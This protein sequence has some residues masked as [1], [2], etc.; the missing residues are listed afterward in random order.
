MKDITKNKA[1]FSV[2]CLQW[3]SDQKL[4]QPTLEWYENCG[5]GR[6][7]EDSVAD[8]KHRQETMKFM[9]TQTRLD[10]TFTE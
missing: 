1:L 7:E 6:T 8:T 4:E 9:R 5:Q 2:C 3:P 10:V